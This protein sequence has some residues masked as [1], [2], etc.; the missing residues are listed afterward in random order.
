M[1]TQKKFFIT[2]GDKLCYD[3]NTEVIQ[4]D[5]QHLEYGS[6]NMTL[7]WKISSKNNCSIRIQSHPQCLPNN[8]VV[9]ATVDAQ[10]QISVSTEEL[11]ISG[12][13]A[14]FVLSGVPA[15]ECPQ[16]SGTLRFNGKC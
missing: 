6:V 12:H 14:D 4:L 3:Q 15:V 16:L 2:L 5:H 11:Y 10:T 8:I 13:L 9:D 1:L 7:S